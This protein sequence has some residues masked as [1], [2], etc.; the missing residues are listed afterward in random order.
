MPFD[1]FLFGS[2]VVAKEAQSRVSLLLRHVSM[3]RNGRVPM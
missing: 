3:M 1:G 2:C